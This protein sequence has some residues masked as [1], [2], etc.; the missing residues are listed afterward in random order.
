LEPIEL[1]PGQVRIR[2]A[3][4][5]VCHSDIGKIGDPDVTPGSGLGHELSGVV[6]ESKSDRFRPEDRV[7]VLHY[8]GY[9]SEVVAD[10]DHVLPVPDAVPLELASLSEPMACVLAGLDR[11]S[12][13]GAGPVAVVGAGFMG[14]LMIRALAIRGMEIHVY[15][16]RSQARDRAIAQGASAVYDR[17]TSSADDR[18]GFDV[19]FECTGAAGGLDLASSLVAISGVLSIV[20]YHQSS[21]GTRQVPMQS[22][23][24]RAIDVVNAHTRSHQE[25]LL[26]MGRALRMMS[27]RVVD[28]QPL[29]TGTVRFEEIPNV[30][31]QTGTARLR[32][33][34]KLVASIDSRPT[35]HSQATELAGA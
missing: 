16:P 7:V 24:Y 34:V 10:D 5:G 11:T 19:V 33:H 12:L 2:I 18:Y 6:S 9:A 22:W 20:G 4:C 32:D 26:Q 17:A 8:E 29:I 13:K 3:F 28:L 30:L 14:L 35:R 21:N 31:T 1:R 15:E 23:N 27:L 25:V